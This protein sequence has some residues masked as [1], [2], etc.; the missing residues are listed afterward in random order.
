MVKK[1][2]LLILAIYIIVGVIFLNEP[3]QLF[4]SVDITDWWIFTAGFLLFVAAWAII[5][6]FRAPPRYY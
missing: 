2:H 4:P 1:S 6:K 3:F 5:V